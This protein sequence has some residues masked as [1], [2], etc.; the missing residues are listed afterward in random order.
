MN[1]VIRHI[2][3]KE[4]LQFRKDKKMFGISIVAPIVQLLLLGYAANIDIKNIPIIICDMDKSRISRS[5]SRSI[6]NSGYFSSVRNTDD[7]DEIDQYINRGIASAGII[8]PH[9]FEKN[10]NSGRSIEVQGI[11][12]GSDSNTAAIGMNYLSMIT[13]QFNQRFISDRLILF[14]KQNINPRKINPEIRIWYNPELKSKNFMIPGVLGLLLMVV[15]LILTSL[16]VVKEKEIGTLEQLNVSPIKPYEL[17]LGKLI[18]FTLIGILDIILVLLV[19]SLWFNIPVKGN[20]LLLFGLSIVF[21]LSTLGMGLFVSTVAS[22]QQQAMITAMFFLMLPMMFLSGFVF[23]IEN[24]PKIIQLVTYVMP[25]RYYY[26]IVRGIFLKGVGIR[27]LWPD[28]LIMFIIGAAIF[29][30]SAL[31]FKKRIG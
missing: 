20:V 6:T 11:I 12:D 21:L 16:A 8:I 5:Y 17:I 1:S 2:V 4:F 29:S 28:A 10:I 25:L 24:M 13:M 15:T 22:N 26:N 9:N 23:P 19:A 27:E 3:K 30:F 31:R 18:P 14:K 7:M